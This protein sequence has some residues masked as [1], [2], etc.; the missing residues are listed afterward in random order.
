MDIENTAASIGNDLFG[1][2]GETETVVAE[3]PSE[4]ETT[5][6][7]EAAAEAPSTAPE[8]P[9]SSETEPAT[10]A[11][12]E[13]LPRTWRKEAMAHWAALPP[14]VKA[15]IEKREGDIFK[16]IE[17]YKPNADIGRALTQ[18]LEPFAQNIRAANVHPL[19]YIQGI[20][21]VDH[22]LRHGTAEQKQAV[23]AKLAENYG[24]LGTQ[25]PEPAYVD[26]QVQSLQSELKDLK[27]R[28]TSRESAEAETL[29]AKLRADID[30]FANDPKNV[31]FNEVAN[32]AAV[33]LQSGAATTLEDAY[34]KAVWANPVTREKEQKRLKTEAD[35]K[36][37]AEA[38]KKA[39]DAAKAKAASVKSGSHPGG[40]PV[41]GQT[42]DQ[43]LAATLKAIRSR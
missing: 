15:E 22:A 20:M 17:Q 3:P 25:L 5:T 12:T 10:P 18:T 21:Q 6:E 34:E 26:P 35:A 28:L 39:E 8:A 31:Y 29:R 7:V 40:K 11:A 43:T 23:W 42:M 13:W 14:E 33:L 36:N 30:K 37:A 16:G 2:G 9:T 19:Q 24:M 41:Q 32:D 4:V 27:S 1:G 38:A